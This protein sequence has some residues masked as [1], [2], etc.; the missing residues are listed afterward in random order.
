MP[1]RQSLVDC[2]Q[3]RPS[4]GSCT[5]VESEAE[6]RPQLTASV[7]GRFQLLAHSAFGN[8]DRSVVSKPAYKP[9]V[10]Q[11]TGHIVNETTGIDEADKFNA[12]GVSPQN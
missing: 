8:M 6:G 12:Q 10:D 11:N 1:G 4:A 5:D 3:F 7:G 9:Q 2:R